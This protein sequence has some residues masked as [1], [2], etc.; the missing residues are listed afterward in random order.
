MVGRLAMSMQGYSTQIPK[1]YV[2]SICVRTA[3][4]LYCNGWTFAYTYYILDDVKDVLFQHHL[5]CLTARTWSMS[6]LSLKVKFKTSFPNKSICK[7]IAKFMTALTWEG[8]ISRV[9]AAL[10][11][12]L[13]SMNLGIIMWSFVSLKI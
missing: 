5:L 7:V 2:T 9:K 11:Y 4:Y 8:F 13:S 6:Y 1:S 3:K 10:F 12:K